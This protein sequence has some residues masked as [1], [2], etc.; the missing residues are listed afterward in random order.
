ML[1][2]HADDPD[3]GVQALIQ[4]LSQP[5]EVPSSCAAHADVDSDANRSD[6]EKKARGQKAADT[7][8]ER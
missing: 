7:R 2:G 4:R 5:R 8:A 6:A 3:A 1:E